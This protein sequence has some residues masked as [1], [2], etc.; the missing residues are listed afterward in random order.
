M[1]DI[2]QAPTRIGRATRKVPKAE[3][4]DDLT[5]Q[6]HDV[7]DIP[8][9]KEEP[10]LDAYGNE[11][12]ADIKYKTMAW[13]QGAM[14]AYLVVPE[15]LS[16]MLYSHD[17]GEHIT[18]HPFSPCRHVHSRLDRWYHRSS[19]IG[20]LLDLLWICAMAIQN[21]VSS[22]MIASRNRLEAW[23]YYVIVCQ[24]GR[25]RRGTPWSFR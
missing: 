8:G 15:M 14:G 12:G 7:E 4:Q 25:C 11:D 21:E 9:L 20:N 17:C 2:T 5:S 1:A 23:A 22:S 19:R 6:Y 10:I 24:H 13:W 18:G 16:L 3:G